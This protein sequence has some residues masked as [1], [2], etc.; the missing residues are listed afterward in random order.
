MKI[1]LTAILLAF[2]Y[3]LYNAYNAGFDSSIVP[4]KRKALAAGVQCSSKNH[5]KITNSLAASFELHQ[6]NRNEPG[7]LLRAPYYRY[8][9][10]DQLSL[11]LQRNFLFEIS[12]IKPVP[13][14]R[15]RA[16]NNFMPDTDCACADKLNAGL[17]DKT[18]NLFFGKLGYIDCRLL[19]RN[20]E[21]CQQSISNTCC[22]TLIKI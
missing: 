21:L 7:L 3:C 2:I 8:C 19:K 13:V 15:L 10:K 9:K 6:F 14:A 11:S 17:R 16:L 18:L 1:K 12:N 5:R 22:S 20:P 4:G